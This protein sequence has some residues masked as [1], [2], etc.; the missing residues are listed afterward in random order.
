MSKW[1]KFGIFFGVVLVAIIG[2]VWCR[3]SEKVV[4]SNGVNLDIARKFYRP[5]AIKRLIDQVAENDGDYLQLHLSDEDNVAIELEILGQTIDKSYVKE[6]IHYNSDSKR[7]FLTKEELA[8]LIDYAN[9]KHVFLVPDFDTPGHFGAAAELLRQNRPQLA[10]KI[11][12]DDQ[13]DYKSS[14]GL[15]FAKELYGEIA[16]IFAGQQA[17]VIGGDEFDGDQRASN[18]SYVTYVNAIS[19]QLYQKGFRTRIWNDTVLK[20]DL[21]H[22]DKEKVQIIYW[23][24]N[25]DANDVNS[26][27]DQQ[28]NEY[29][30]KYRASLPDL[31]KAGFKVINANSYHLYSVPSQSN[32]VELSATLEEDI[33]QTLTRWEPNLWNG[34]NRPTDEVPQHHTDSKVLVGSLYSIWS[35]EASDL[36]DYEVVDAYGPTLEVF[37]EKAKK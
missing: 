14:E 31:Q 16:E 34:T 24:L 17:I 6:G 4:F 18:L 25:G 23:S 29:R 28:A 37:F 33:E 20:K 5:A 32:L 19:K 27:W 3:P 21:V 1:R 15:A 35:E 2:F 7:P 8:D 26:D 9:N 30:V 13:L 10:K 36:S 12:A 22:F 11:L